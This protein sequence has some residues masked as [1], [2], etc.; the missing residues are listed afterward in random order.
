MSADRD[1]RRAFVDAENMH[2]GKFLD[3]ECLIG[4][5]RSYVCEC[6][7][8][9]ACPGEIYAHSRSD[10]P[11]KSGQLALFSSEKSDVVGSAS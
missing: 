9:C 11:K 10:C 1:G 2:L 8:R 7:F 3:V 6:G 4:W 5:R